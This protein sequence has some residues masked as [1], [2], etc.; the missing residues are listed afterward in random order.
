[1]SANK[2][3]WVGRVYLGRD[4]D[5]KQE[6]RW[7]GRF[8]T[9]RE[10]DDA[11]A[12]ARVELQ[13]ERVELPTV[14]EYVDRYLADYGRTKK[15][16]SL[17]AQTQRLKRFRKDFAGRSIDISRAEAKDWV[18]GEGIWALKGPVPFSIPGAVV[19]LYN[20]AINEDD[21]P[22]ERN[23]FRGLG[24]R[25][26]GRADQAPP[27]EA[28][29]Q[30]LLDSCSALGAYADQ[31]RAF[32][33]F[34]AFTLMRPSEV[35]ELE[36]A[37]IDFARMRIHKARRLYRGTV[38]EPKT[39]KK[40][41]ALTPPARDAIIGLSRDRGRL[42]FTTKTGLR[43]SQTTMHGYWGKVLAKADLDF[44]LYH[45]TKHYGVHYMWTKLQLPTR[46]IAA[47]AGW[48]LETV[49]K[50]LA[51]YGHGEVG[52][53]EELDQAFASVDNVVQLP[54]PKAVGE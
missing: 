32:L 45:A 17:D 18:N 46:V 22:L 44:D 35:Y 37:D 26:K 30:K 2:K 3:T 14:D 7:V 15:A 21:L 43:L 8:S 41:I 34:S 19:T 20:H 48:S 27:T 39:G 13:H 51:V 47:Q 38:D 12:K 50:M 23:P 16:S 52:A 33:Q 42:V 40:L 10:R 11:V 1:M 5:G 54:R 25:G 4:K 29:F 24:K 53:L 9:K 49:D 28:E 36:W 31:M 6:F